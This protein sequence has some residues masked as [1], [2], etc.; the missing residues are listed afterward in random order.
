MNNWVQ[1][2]AVLE[3]IVEGERWI[4]KRIRLSTISGDRMKVSQWRG[5]MDTMC[6]DLQRAARKQMEDF[7]WSG[8]KREGGGDVTDLLIRACFIQGLYDEGIQTMV[9]TAGSINSPMAQLV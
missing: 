7:A 9:K 3:I 5:Q 6:G 8:E 2:K 1:S 4:T